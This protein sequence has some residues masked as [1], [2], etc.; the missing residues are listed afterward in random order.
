MTAR[1]DGVALRLW[2]TVAVILT[3][4]AATLLILAPVRA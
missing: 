3:I 2:F 4:L 1:P